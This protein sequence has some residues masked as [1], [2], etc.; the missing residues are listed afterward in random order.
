MGQTLAAAARQ[1]ATEAQAFQAA[2]PLPELVAELGQG[3]LA[4]RSRQSCRG[5]IK[6]CGKA[7]GQQHRFGATAAPPFL[8]AAADQRGQGN[9]GGQG[10]N[11]HPPRTLQFVGGATEQIHRQLRQVQRQMAHHLN[12]VDMQAHPGVAAEGPETGQRLQ[13]AHL[14]LTPDQRHQP[15]GRRQPLR[16]VLG[17]DQ[18]KP[19]DR[20]DLHLPALPLQLGRR[21]QR[22]RMFDGG[23]QQAAGL[24]QGGT[25]QQGQMDRLT[26]AGAENQLR[27]LGPQVGGE[28]DAAA[29]QQ[30]GGG[31]SRAM[32]AGGIGPGGA[33]LSCH[34][35]E[36]LS[37]GGAGGRSIE[38]TS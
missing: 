8:R 11:A 3:I 31:Q 29:F 23:H 17:I 34:R 21:R 35:R 16:Q 7:M 5:Q 19:V 30:L 25:A 38:I 6:G 15:G 18:A 24:Q 10:Q 32:Q 1:R 2:E 12:G 28:P 22:G 4:G 37:G 13:A 33:S 36:H 14:A 26:A 9:A 20:Q 27:G